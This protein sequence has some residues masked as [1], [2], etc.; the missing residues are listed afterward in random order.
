MF[1]KNNLVGVSI[2]AIVALSLVGCSS[3]NSSS[4]A[5][6]KND[7]PLATSDNKTACS[8]LRYIYSRNSGVIQ[9]WANQAATDLD[10]AKAMQTIGKNFSDIGTTASGELQTVILNVGTSYKKMYVALMNGDS[11]TLEAELSNALNYATTFDTLCT[12]I[13]E[14]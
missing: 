12:S 14:K 9:D 7:N 8:A 2:A 13:G 11:G 6:A 4:S 1:T 3:D 5:S 10:A